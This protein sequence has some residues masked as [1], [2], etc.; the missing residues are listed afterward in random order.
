LN[1]STNSTMA[2]LFTG[3]FFPYLEESLLAEITAAKQEDPFRP[4]AV[5]V[6]TR[7]L[8]R[9][10]Q[11]IL[12]AR[13]PWVN[14]HF[15]TFFTL[16]LRLL[17]AAGRQVHP[18]VPEAV[19]LLLL[20]QVIES[21]LPQ[22]EHTAYFLSY[23]SSLAR[24]LSLFSRFTSYRVTPPA[25][26]T[27]IEKTVFAIYRSFSDEKRKQGLRDADDLIDEAARLF[28][29]RTPPDTPQDIFLYGF[30]DLNPVQADIVRSLDARCDLTIVSAG[31]FSAG[32]E[33]FFER[34]AQFYRELAGAAAD[35]HKA[36]PTETD[37]VIT[38]IARELFS[39]RG[40]ERLEAGGC[41]EL[42]TASGVRG[43]ARAVALSIIGLMEKDPSLGWREIAVTMRQRADYAGALADAFA[44]YSIPAV[45]DGGQP[46]SSIPEVGYFLVLISALRRG[47]VRDDVLFLISSA[48]FAWPGL[49]ADDEPWV[50]DNA[51]L[52]AE[53]AGA[54]RIIS[55]TRE[56]E[57]AFARHRDRAAVDDNPED[58]PDGT[59]ADDR[60]QPMTRYIRAV[61]AIVGGFLSA[62]AEI[63]ADAPPAEFRDKLTRLID[64]YILPSH[65]NS[66][67]VGYLK[68]ILGT[69]TAVSLIRP[70]ITRH[71][72][73]AILENAISLSNAPGPDDID[74]VFV[75]DVM[76]ARLLPR[77]VIILMGMNEK[78][79][80]H[81]AARDPFISDETG[82][83]LGLRTGAF[84]LMED[85]TLFALTVACARDLIVISRERSD[86]AGRTVSPSPFLEELLSRITIGGNKVDPAA[87]SAGRD[88][89]RITAA[90]RE[91]SRHR[92]A[93]IRTF[94]C[95]G[96]P[97]EHDIR[98][99]RGVVAD[100][101]FLRGGLTAVDER[102]SNR[103]LS[104]YDGLIG[105]ADGL[106]DV[107]AP[108]SAQKLEAYAACPFDFFMRYIL[109]VPEDEAVEEELDVEPRELGNIYHR[110][111]S[112][113]LPLLVQK[114]LLAATADPKV[115]DRLVDAHV[116]KE[117][118]SR[119]SGRIPALI[120]R[121]RGQHTARI[122]RRLIERERDTGTSGFVPAHYE[123]TFG[124]RR[125]GSIEYPALAL[126]IGTHA[127][128]CVG[129]IDRIDINR[130]EAAFSV[131]DYKRKKG[132]GALK[133]MTRIRNGQHFQ[134]PIYLMAA[135]HLVSK[136]QYRPGGGALVYLEADDAAKYREAISA[137]EFAQARDTV[138]GRIGA[139]LDAI[140]A[141]EFT[142]G[143]GGSCRF[144]V[145]GDLCRSE[146]KSVDAERRQKTA[147]GDGTPGED[148]D[149][150]ES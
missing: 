93:D 125:D 70:R 143:K 101:P 97:D 43:E 47:L 126:T 39:A 128:D 9:R 20:K 110:I 71:D 132:S 30:Y 60:D 22:N 55:G 109:L 67:G 88:Y 19:L 68:E 41:I 75:S 6:P 45:F 87:G 90:D 26:P 24:L 130:A 120:L 104:R 137:E 57:N 12:A 83:A 95:L 129:R 92:E 136:G 72:C 147:D 49:A 81:V 52:L 86:D 11:S 135:E 76:G 82:A 140:A 16:S 119:L 42:M 46:L 145:H 21:N 10:L 51:Y 73:L 59:P 141:G 146:S 69:L 115:V 17:S 62:L 66:P 58:E 116:T 113:L 102:A 105:S 14:V 150:D 77:R 84:R 65:D 121:A 124:P 142:P 44:D 25:E 89:P 122:V 107:I 144:C 8:V 13:G 28:S 54:Y 63:P 112:R 31:G 3:P 5:I 94:L 1:P 38:S 134:L 80:P 127:I 106:I 50:R 74:G 79:F 111:L 32:A 40:T 56:W 23:D 96:W 35:P 99:V 138:M 2:R 85:R 114:G 27:G 117:T 36:L 149:T 133:L 34:T 78:I 48:L 131:I 91:L 108:L 33:E 98:A 18:T 4:V 139:V 123:V 53:F 148:E 103:P 64:T 118:S 15:H 37:S 29:D 100:T 7:A 61:Q